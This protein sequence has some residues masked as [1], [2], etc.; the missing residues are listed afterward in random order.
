MINKYKDLEVLIATQNRKSL[1]FLSKMFPHQNFLNFFVLIIN[2]TTKDCLL[3]SDHPNVRVINSF[4]RGLSNSR[5]LALKESKCE[6]VL[7]SDDDL[8]YKKGFQNAVLNGFN[9]NTNADLI[10]FK[11][12]NLE[13]DAYRS[14]PINSHRHNIKSI[15]GVISWEIALNVKRVKKIAVSFDKRFGLG[16][17]FPTSEEY[18]FAR[19]IIDTGGNCYFCNEQIVS[20]PT[21][22]SGM[23]L[24]SYKIIYARAA[25]NYK[26][27][28]NLAYAWL[29]K[30]IFFL[31]THNYINRY[32]VVSKFRTGLK[33][34][35]DFRLNISTCK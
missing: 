3:K 6:I 11:A 10:T 26:L 28:K 19:N 30:F 27:H 22:N 24:G 29:L 17:Q 23:D 13:G 9:H 33:G 2:Q 12:N 14:Y 1:Q 7:I 5:N 4:E 31:L 20:H 15:K 16:S 21:F 32:E 34:I 25:L 8:V 18:L 35:R